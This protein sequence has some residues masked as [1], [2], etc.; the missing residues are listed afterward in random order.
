MWGGHQ[1]GGTGGSRSRTD[2]G[3]YFSIVPYWCTSHIAHIPTFI[4]GLIC[5]CCCPHDT[6]RCAYKHTKFTHTNQTWNDYF[7]SYK[8]LLRAGHD[9]ATP[10]IAPTMAS[11]SKF[12]QWVLL[13]GS[14]LKPRLLWPD[15]GWVI[16]YILSFL[17]VSES[18]LSRCTQLSGEQ[19]LQVQSM[20]RN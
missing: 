18:T 3:Y 5:L 1:K 12:G 15:Y 2:A 9:P 11:K 14:W 4:F 17:H 20:A 6:R 13:T 19:W 10:T 16:R 7:T 8:C